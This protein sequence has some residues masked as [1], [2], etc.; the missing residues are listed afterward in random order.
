MRYIREIDRDH[1]GFV[2]N[3]ELEDIMKMLYPQE[4][5]NKDL[6][7]LFKKFE[8]IQNKL[9]IDYKKLSAYIKDELNAHMA[10]TVQSH[11]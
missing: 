7:R 9:L 4:F 1:N 11:A 8:S 10:I 6:K 2:T 5:E 3:Q